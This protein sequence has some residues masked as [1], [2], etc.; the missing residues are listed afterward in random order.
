MSNS[1]KR[2]KFGADLED[3]IRISSSESTDEKLIP[4]SLE[5]MMVTRLMPGTYQPR[6]HFDESSLRSLA[7]SIKEKGI[8]QPIIVR[9]SGPVD[10][11]IIAGERRW[12]AAQ[13]AGLQQVPVIIKEISNEN[14]LAFG[15]VENI[16]RSDLNPIEEA[17]AITRLIKEFHYTHEQVGKYIGRS[18][19]SISN[20]LRLLKLDEAVKDM[21]RLGKLDMGQSR[22]ILHLPMTLQAMA[23]ETIYKE[24]MSARETERYVKRLSKPKEEGRTLDND[25]VQFKKRLNQLC[26]ELSGSLGVS[27]DVSLN[28]DGSGKFA[29]SFDSKHLA[30]YFIKTLSLA[31]K[32]QTLA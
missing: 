28:K 7:D 26:N 3:I 24:K 16:Q 9:K 13:M 2:K 1:T 30:E 4:G 12:R 19:A 17:E 22:A 18:R 25:E 20:A 21:L 27:I 23:A 31:A 15:L 5:M 10:Y 29:V 32:K 11:E 6:R 14:A 8:L